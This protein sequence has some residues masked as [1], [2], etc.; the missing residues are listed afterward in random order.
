MNDRIKLGKDGEDRAVKILKK[1]GYR[2]LER[3]FH[4]GLGEIDIIAKDDNVLVFIEV[5]TRSNL[6]FGLPQLSVDTRKQNRLIKLALLYIKQRNIKTGDIRFDV[7]AL[8]PTTCE[9][10]K[11]AFSSTDRYTL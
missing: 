11:N 7:L 9:L 2:I 3:N 8:T 5:K 10:I 1:N 4:T 6:S